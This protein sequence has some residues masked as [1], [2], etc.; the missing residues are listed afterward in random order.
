MGRFWPQTIQFIDW[1]TPPTPDSNPFDLAIGGGRIWF[2]EAGADRV[3]R[4]QAGDKTIVEYG[5]QAG[6]DPRGIAVDEQGCVWVALHGQNSV[7]SLCLRSMYL[8]LVRK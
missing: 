5:L 8:P 6:S 3:G 2:S 7:K 1:W 4:T